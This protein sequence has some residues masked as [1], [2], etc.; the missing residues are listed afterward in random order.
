[1]TRVL[2][3]GSESTPVGTLRATLRD[4]GAEV[5]RV[6][7]AVEAAEA[8][9]RDRYDCVAVCDSDLGAEFVERRLRERGRGVPVVGATDDAGAAERVLDA[10][11]EYRFDETRA[12]RQRRR[13]A[14][15]D[16][17]AAVTACD[18]REAVA[19]AATTGLVDGAAYRAAW[20][21]RWDD[22]RG[23]LVPVAAAGLELAT[24]REVPAGR[25]SPVA[26]RV[27]VDWEP[28]AERVDA[29]TTIAVP[30]VGADP[31]GVLQVYADRPTGVSEAEHDLLADLADAVADALTDAVGSDDADPDDEI[32]VLGDTL[33]HELGNQLDAARVQLELA[34]ERDDDDH[35]ERVE[36]A[37]E[38]MGS[39]AADARALAR[40]VV[41][42]APRD[43]P[44]AA[45]R[46]WAAVETRDAELTVEDG[47][48][49]ADADLLRLLFENLF[50][51]AVQHAGPEVT[52]TVGPLDGGFY[53]A[54]DGPGVPAD[55]RDVV[56]EW[57]YSSRDGSGAGLG[58]V[59]LVAGRHGWSVALEE[60]AD[61]GARFEFA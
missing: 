9:T 52:V 30:V 58:I 27:A 12:R 25:D 26:G 15:A 55:E 31:Q 56:F 13:A 61:G 40:G 24:L 10:A 42:A 43:L 16:V 19:R 38:R 57:G 45:E 34:R 44:D 29:T 6:P 23:V 1:M 47:V 54:D 50:R 53:V 32:R 3:V 2:L 60:S 35:F 11:T 20:Y 14:V 41:D 37:L 17:R 4:A 49:V 8:L 28:V 51:N 21:G 48:V 46:A 39:V 22:A 33:A 5:T 18:D 36:D 59:S 7:D